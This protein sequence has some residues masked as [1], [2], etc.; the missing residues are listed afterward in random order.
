[1][2]II[3]QPEKGKLHGTNFHIFATGRN[4]A[5]LLGLNLIAIKKYIYNKLKLNSIRL[6]NQGTTPQH[7]NSTLNHLQGPTR[8]SPTPTDWYHRHSSKVNKTHKTHN[9]KS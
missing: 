9:R 1:M 7:Q 8:E 6:S 4:N 3:C 2:G 5:Y